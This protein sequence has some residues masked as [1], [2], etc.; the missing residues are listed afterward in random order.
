MVAQLWT[1]RYYNDISR[2]VYQLLGQ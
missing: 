2:G 1:H